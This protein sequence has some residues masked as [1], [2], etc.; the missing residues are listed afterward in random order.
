[1]HRDELQQRIEDLFEKQEKSDKA[2]ALLKECRELLMQGEIRVAE[3]IDVFNAEGL[4][5]WKV[6]VWVKKAIVLMASSGDLQKM[7]TAHPEVWGT[8]VDTLPWRH[9]VPNSC[10]MPLGSHMREGAYM[11]PG[12]TCMPPSVIQIGTYIGESSAIDSMVSIGLGAQIGSGTQLS[13]RV[14]IG[15]WMI[16]LDHLPT[17]VEDGALLG[18]GS[19]VY[20][21]AMVGKGAILLAGTQMIPSLGILDLRDGS[22]TQREAGKPLIVPPNS[23]VA[24][25]SRAVLGGVAIQTPVIVGRRT[26]PDARSWE[27]YSDIAF[28]IP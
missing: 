28:A 3:P 4:R 1:M 13:C 25:G 15:G 16:P 8:E 24:M 10:R 17:I 9:G 14:T 18:T 22:H 2:R 20:D 6:N 7:Q 27:R 5:P 12:V 11:G 23:I 19:G 26:G 21:G